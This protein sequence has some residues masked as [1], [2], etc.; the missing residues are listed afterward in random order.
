MYSSC[1][2]PFNKCSGSDLTVV[3]SSTAHVLISCTVRLPDLKAGE[4]VRNCAR[5]DVKS[6]VKEV[7]LN[8]LVSGVRV[9]QIA[10]I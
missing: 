1:C 7:Q 3:L 2:V 8:F 6:E 9:D 5:T 10:P 4:L